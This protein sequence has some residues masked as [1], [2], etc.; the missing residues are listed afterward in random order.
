[1]TGDVNIIDETFA[2]TPEQHA[3]LLYTLSARP[4]P[5]LIYTSSPPLKGDQAPKMYE[6]RRRGDP[7]APRTPEDGP[8]TQ[9]PSLG[10]RDWGHAGDLENP[11]VDIDSMEVA[12]AANP[13]LGV[14]RPSA[15]ALETFERELASDRA[16]YPRERLGI[17]PREVR[18]EGSRIDAR[19]WASLGD[20]QS[21][22]AGD[23]ALAIAVAQDRSWSALAVCGLR[24]DKLRHWEVIDHRRGQ[25]DW[26]V[27]RVE[28]FR[29]KH[30]RD[31][32]GVAVDERGPAGSLVP[33]LERAGITRPEKADKP[34][35]GDLAVLTAGDMAAA[36]GILM[37][38]VTGKRARHR[39][40]PRL[41]TALSAAG[42]RVIGDGAEAWG[43]KGAG[44]ITCLEA[45]TIADWLHESWAH[46]VLDD[47]PPNIW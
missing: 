11:L 38:H 25:P 17:W 31:L 30:G 18:S 34:Q 36:F 46:L 21:R 24:E 33:A 9:D 3:A 45:V 32:I 47:A 35:R 20:P 5:Q 4:N 6:L 7:S 12:A 44:D 2:Y 10:Y 8:W 28:E 14:D 43:R 40:D 42:T 16:G 22:R 37:D 39:D 41:N 1:M 13:A 19:L 15:L 23:V 26:V 27:A 29:Q